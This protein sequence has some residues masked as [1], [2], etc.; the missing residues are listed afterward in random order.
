MIV[1]A[2]EYGKQL[3]QTLIIQQNPKQMCKPFESLRYEPKEDEPF[4][5]CV[6]LASPA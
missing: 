1:V 2:K 5:E 6:K 4:E 3:W